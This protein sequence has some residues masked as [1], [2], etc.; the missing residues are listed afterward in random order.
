MNIGDFMKRNVVSIPATATIGEAAVIFVQNHIG[1]LPVVD[2]DRKLVGILH[3]RDL[4]KLIMPTF[5]TLIRDFD[6]VRHDFGD[7]EHL[8]PSL[9]M[10]AHPV[11]E[12]MEEAVSVQATSG[13]LRAFALLDHDDRYDLPVVDE[14]DRL[15]GLAS[16]V[17]IGSALLSGWHSDLA[18]GRS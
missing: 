9:E 18:P 15:V 1:T 6:F 4:L 13:L 5:V 10:E 16:R 17:D 3:M 14:N 11:S 12:V 8:R 7:F 2:S